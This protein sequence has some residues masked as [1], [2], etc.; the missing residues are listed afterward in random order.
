MFFSYVPDLQYDTKPSK[1]PFGK[2]DYVIVKNFFRRYKI[3]EDMLSYAVFFQKYS[4]TD[5]DRL[6]LLAEKAYG[7]P[8]YDWV[9]AILN[10]IINPVLDW[11]MN[12]YQLRKYVEEKYDEPD[13]IHHYETLEVKDSNSKL[14]LK[15]GVI[16]DEN[17]YNNPFKFYDSKTKKPSTKL[18]AAIPVSNFEYEFKKNESK[19]EIYLLKGRYFDAFVNEFR[20]LNL[21][22]KSSDYISSQLKKTSV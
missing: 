15:E 16:V 3:N 20:K 19:R 12:E 9:I 10:N 14:V 5:S 8:Y 17:F 13:G 11:P 21:Y 4:I 7:S 22:S 1:F 18:N 6:D 2:T